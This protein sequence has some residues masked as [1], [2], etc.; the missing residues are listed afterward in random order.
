MINQKRARKNMFN[1]PDQR[2]PDQT[3]ILES[4]NSEIQKYGEEKQQSQKQKTHNSKLRNMPKQMENMAYADSF[5][6]ADLEIDINEEVH[7]QQNINRAVLLKTNQYSFANKKGL[8][9]KADETLNN[10]K[11]ETILTVEGEENLDEEEDCDKFQQNQKTRLNS[12]QTHNIHTK[13]LAYESYYSNKI[14]NQNNNDVNLSTASQLDQSTQ[15]H[16]THYHSLQVSKDRSNLTRQRVLESLN[17]SPMTMPFSKIQSVANTHY[18][19]PK[20]YSIMQSQ[21]RAKIPSTLSK[22]ASAA[23]L[24]SLQK[25]NDVSK[26][27]FKT[28]VKNTPHKY[29]NAKEV[30]LRHEAK[31]QQ[32]YDSLKRLMQNVIETPDYYSNLSQLVEIIPVKKEETEQEKHAKSQERNRWNERYSSLTISNYLDQLSTPYGIIACEQVEQYQLSHKRI[33]SNSRE[34]YWRDHMATNINGFNA[35]KLVDMEDKEIEVSHL[36]L[37]KHYDHKYQSRVA[38]TYADKKE[39]SDQYKSRY[40]SLNQTNVLAIK[41]LNFYNSKVF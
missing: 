41:M 39:K 24:H 22:Y 7:N 33:A 28:S 18:H 5:N 16:H 29:S 40:K 37:R 9:Q 14:I 10:Q 32:R 19:T 35:Y 21:T 8:K 27:L 15:Q 2:K 1:P 17:K 23:N 26:M 20:K 25:K 30:L 36:K 6:F 12:Y 3:A 11:M 4:I 13:K 38:L 34:K 31:S